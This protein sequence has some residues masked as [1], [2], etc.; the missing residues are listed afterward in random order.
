MKSDPHLLKTPPTAHRDR[1]PAG[2]SASLDADPAPCEL[3]TFRRKPDTLDTDCLEEFAEVLRRRVLRGREFHCL[4]TGD[5]ELKRLNGQF[6][7]KDVPT[8]VLSFPQEDDGGYVGDLAI[9]LGRARAQAKQFGHS[10]ET[11]IR[12]LMLHGALHL[13]GLDHETDSGQMAHTETKWRKE[14]ALP[15]GLVERTT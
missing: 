4:I 9:S 10:I 12:V 14:F 7:G 15:A 2:S 5:A 13:K 1:L 6:R 11:E 8:D 3:I